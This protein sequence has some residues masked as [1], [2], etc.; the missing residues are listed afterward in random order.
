[1]KAQSVVLQLGAVQGGAAET[2]HVPLGSPAS[3]VSGEDSFG[4][5]ENAQALWGSGQDSRCL[6]PSV[7]QVKIKFRAVPLTEGTFHI[8][9]F[10]AFKVATSWLTKLVRGWFKELAPRVGSKSMF[11]KL[12]QKAD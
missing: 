8:G 2:G 3:I 4:R 5:C 9:Q 1:M 11:K 10:V 12:V 7:W 6:S